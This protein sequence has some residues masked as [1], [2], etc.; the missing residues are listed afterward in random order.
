MLDVRWILIYEN[1]ASR[2]VIMCSCF[3]CAVCL[4]PAGR[5]GVIVARLE[6]ELLQQALSRSVDL[7]LAAVSLVEDAGILVSELG[8]EVATAGNEAVER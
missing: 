3:S 1:Y 8:L 5:G 4:H 6:V 7:A 2:C